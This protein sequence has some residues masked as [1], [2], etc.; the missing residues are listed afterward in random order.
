VKLLLFDL[1]GTVL[2]SVAGAAPFHAAMRETFGVEVDL[3]AIR[4]DGK[5]DPLII[6]E[7]LAR[8]GVRAALDGATL[9]AF[10]ARLAA[11]MAAA[12]ASGAARVEAIP[13]VRPVLEALAHD[14][15]FALG[16]L[17]GNLERPARLKLRAAGLDGLLARGAFGSDGA[18]RAALPDVARA[19]F[20]VEAGL[21]VRRED[22]VIVGDTPLDHAA[23]EANGMPCVLVAS[24]RT[25]FADLA[26]LDPAAV[27][28]DWTDAAAIRR[29]FASL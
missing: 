14:A 17:T 16:V 13:G 20:R 12:L 7:L 19:R 5:T 27:F 2:R 15:R 28:P 9:A 18:A 25:P 1:D 23:A 6:A 3:H 29:T 8:R 10:E 21:D 26:R 4:P 11:R 24:G 22:C